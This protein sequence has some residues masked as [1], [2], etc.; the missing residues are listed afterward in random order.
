MSI[1]EDY[2]SLN[3]AEEIA[4]EGWVLCGFLINF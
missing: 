1:Y 4:G 3:M 2:S